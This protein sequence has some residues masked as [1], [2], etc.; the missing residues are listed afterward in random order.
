MKTKQESIMMQTDITKGKARFHSYKRKLQYILV[1]ENIRVTKEGRIIL[2]ECFD[3]MK[4]A[5]D[6]LG[7]GLDRNMLDEEGSKLL[8]W[9]M[10]DCVSITNQLNLCKRC[11]L[12]RQEKSLKRSHVFPKFFF[13]E[14]PSDKFIFGLD[15][16]Q[17]KSAGACHYWMLCETCEQ[18]LSQNG[19]NDFKTKF[20][21]SGEITYS[22]WLFSFCVGVIFRCL[23]VTFHFPMHF[24]DSAVHKVLLHCRKHLLSLPVTVS[25]K[26]ASLGEQ[27]QD[28]TRQLKDNLDIYLFMSPLNSKQNYGVCQLPYPKSAFALSR[29]KQL[30]NNSLI[31][32]G[33][34]HFF[35][36]WCGPITLIVKFDHFSFKNR[37]F[38]IT[39]NP[40]DSDQ[41]YIIPSEEDRVKLLPLGVWLLLEQL[42]EGSMENSNKVFR[43]MSSECKRKPASQPAQVVPSVDVPLEINAKA[44]FHLSHLPKG[45]EIIKPNLRLP[46]NQCVVLPKGHQV[47]IHACK[48]VPI[49]NMM[50]TFLLCID[51]LKSTTGQTELYVLFLYQDNNKHISKVDGALTEIKDNKLVCTEYLLQGSVPDS[52]RSDISQLNDQLN[53]VMPNKHFDNINLLIYLVKCRRYVVAI[54]HE[55]IIYHY[56]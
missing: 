3:S 28:L 50:V 46:R 45:Y 39:S 1:K 22:T 42:A 24:N 15:K 40:N 4:E 13:K 17:I 43:F 30:D 48:A 47:I 44:T 8:D 32:N 55:I 31:F 35:C 6:L 16:Y 27:L 19:E 36:L 38:H 54:N 18:V 10:I 2:N 29:N 52:F 41:K 37:G 34:A 49:K 56:I 20:P 14:K 7:K 23:S 21:T 26:V 12:C 51:M 11:L 5:I 25:G 9:A 33:Y 53:I